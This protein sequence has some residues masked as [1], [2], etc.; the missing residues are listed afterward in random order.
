[1]VGVGE[2]VVRVAGARVELAVVRMGA[3]GMEVVGMAAV[4]MGVVVEGEEGAGLGTLA[5]VAVVVM[6]WQGMVGSVVVA[7][8]MVV[9]WEVAW[10]A[11]GLVDLVGW[12]EG[13]VLEVEGVREGRG[14]G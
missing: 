5:R 3:V 1:M 9:A 6:R 10:A 4:V 8:V 11:W 7:V 2:G 12:M 14:V 13:V